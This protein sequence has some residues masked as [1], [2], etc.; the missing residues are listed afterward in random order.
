MRFVLPDDVIE[1]AFPLIPNFLRGICFH[2]LNA[3]TAE[4]LAQCFILHK[5]FKR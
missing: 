3:L 4:L 2:V 5:C 1:N